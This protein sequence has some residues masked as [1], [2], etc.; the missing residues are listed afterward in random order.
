MCN[1]TKTKWDRLQQALSIIVSL[2]AIY[3]LI[4][5]YLQYKA[6]QKEQLVKVAMEVIQE[7][8][9][10][11]FLDSYGRFASVYANRRRPEPLDMDRILAGIYCRA[12]SLQNA[13]AYLLDVNFI[14]GVYDHAACLYLKRYADRQ[15]IDDHLLNQLRAFKVY[16]NYLSKE[17]HGE[18]FPNSKYVEDY[19]VVAIKSSYKGQ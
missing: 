16:Y 10:K 7:T 15:T 6:H 13:H 18:G 4:F 9:K 12:N 19:L 11:D 3:G 1:G 8:K 2:V 14:L 5:T 17:T